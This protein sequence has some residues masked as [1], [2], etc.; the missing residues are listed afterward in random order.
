MNGYGHKGCNAE[1]EYCL[2]VCWRF[3]SRWRL[4]LGNSTESGPTL[5]QATFDKFGSCYIFSF[6][7]LEGTFLHP[8]VGMITIP[9]KKWWSGG[10][11]MALWHCFTNIIGGTVADDHRQWPMMNDD[12][13]LLPI[14]PTQPGFFPTM[15]WSWPPSKGSVG[16]PGTL[17]S[18]K[19]TVRN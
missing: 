15:R 2:T 19:W 11:F 16:T 4:I 5:S 13:H 7:V 14:A 17:Y 18:P 9:P 10:W 6:P 3:D 12:G 1:T 8:G